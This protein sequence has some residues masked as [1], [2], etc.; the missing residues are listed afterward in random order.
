MRVEL[1]EDTVRRPSILVTVMSDGTE[2]L[3]DI[4]VYENVLI[5]GFVVLSYVLVGKK[6]GLRLVFAVI[7]ACLFFLYREINFRSYIYDIK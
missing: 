1:D 6:S 3:R 2:L 4:V 7:S 5:F